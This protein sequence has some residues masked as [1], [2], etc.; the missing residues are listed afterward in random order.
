MAKQ[1]ESLPVASSTMTQGGMEDDE[2]NE[3]DF[4]I[5][6]RNEQEGGNEDRFVVFRDVR[7]GIICQCTH[8]QDYIDGN[9]NAHDLIRFPV[10][11]YK[12]GRKRAMTKKCS[13]CYKCCMKPYC[14]SLLNKHSQECFINHIPAR[15]SG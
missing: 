8:V 1:L 4:D 2:G 15:T 9:G 13:T 14:N 10:L 5:D 6:V 11:E 3:S 12:N 7:G